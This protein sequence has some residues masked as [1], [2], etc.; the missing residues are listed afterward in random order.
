M[1]APSNSSTAVF[2]DKITKMRMLAKNLFKEKEKAQ[3]IS[4]KDTSDANRSRVTMIITL[5]CAFLLIGGR[6]L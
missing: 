3:T 6:V 5:M 4:I 2:D 1:N